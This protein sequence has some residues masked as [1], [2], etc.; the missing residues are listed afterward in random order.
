G[1]EWLHAMRNGNGSW[2]CFVRGGRLMFDAPC[3][4]CTSHA[5][6][7][8]HAFPGR[9]HRLDRAVRWLARAQRPAGAVWC[10]WFR[11][12]PAGTAR[13]LE[14]LGELGLSGSETARGCLRWLLDRQTPA[15]GWGDGRGAEPTVEETAWAVLGLVGAGQ[16][17]HPAA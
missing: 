1:V 11:G 13:A 3:A 10:V 6:V 8:L 9:E 7:A 5:A 12:L 15:G 2:S 16:A 14:P 17:G 4:A